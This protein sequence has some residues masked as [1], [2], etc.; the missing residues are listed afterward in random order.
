MTTSPS[1][2][3]EINP[4]DLCGVCNTKRDEHGDKQHVFDLDGNLV[5]KKA[6][7]PQRRQPPKTR[8]E[9][10][11]AEAVKPD[12]HAAVL[13]LSE[14]LLQKGIIDSADLFYI[15]GGHVVLNRQ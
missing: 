3:S 9:A 7:E 14:I 6:P 15:L 12:A 10:A 8:E 4:D 13:R 2:P 5:P 11:A 1:S